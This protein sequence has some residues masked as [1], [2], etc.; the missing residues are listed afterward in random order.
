MK[1]AGWTVTGL[2]PDD[3]ARKNALDINGLQL[4]APENLYQFFYHAGIG[5]Q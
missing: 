5:Q 4:I 2:E 3:T 1:N